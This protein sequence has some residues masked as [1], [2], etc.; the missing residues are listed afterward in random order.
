MEI[1]F[2]NAK[3]NVPKEYEEGK[4]KSYVSYL[5]FIE[6]AFNSPVPQGMTIVQM[7]E[8][9]NI[10]ELI[11]DKDVEEVTFNEKQFDRVKTR[12]ENTTWNQRIQEVIE[13]YDYVDALSDEIK[14]KK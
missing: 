6:I 1:V 7:R 8:E 12:L 13:L 9:M 3:T 11:E 14:T 4:V 10:L 2:K 5:D